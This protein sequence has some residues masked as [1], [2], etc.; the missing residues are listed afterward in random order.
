MVQPM[1]VLMLGLGLRTP[2]SLTTYIR[3]GVLRPMVHGHNQIFSSNVTAWSQVWLMIRGRECDARS[4]LLSIRGYSTD[5]DR[6]LDQMKQSL[7]YKQKVVKGGKILTRLM[8][9]EVWRPFLITNLTF[10]LQV[11]TVIFH[12]KELERKKFYFLGFVAMRGYSVIL[13]KSS[14]TNLNAYDVVLISRCFTL[15]GQLVSSVAMPYIGRKLVYCVSCALTGVSLIGFGWAHWL[16]PLNS[17]PFAVAIRN[18]TTDNC[19][20]IFSLNLYILSF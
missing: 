11:L 2:W 4:S 3:N 9:Q 12:I 16:H 6:E 20:N 15:L 5:V 7:S 19:K 17:Q 8:E 18:E 10:S 1:Y 14:G 13:L